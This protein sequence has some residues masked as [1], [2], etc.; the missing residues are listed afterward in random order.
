M[1]TWSEMANT[2]QETLKINQNDKSNGEIQNLGKHPS[3]NIIAYQLH[4]KRTPEIVLYNVLYNVKNHT[5]L[6]DTDS[7]RSS[8]RSSEVQTMSFLLFLT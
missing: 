6:N 3:Q 8:S 5:I 7:K 2:L 1:Q 4:E